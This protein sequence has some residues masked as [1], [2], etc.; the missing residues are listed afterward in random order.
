MKTTVRTWRPWP[1]ELAWLGELT[2]PR[3][4]PASQPARTSLLQKSAGEPTLAGPPARGRLRHAGA[5]RFEDVALPRAHLGYGTR[6]TPH[7]PRVYVRVLANLATC[8]GASQGGDGRGEIKGG[9][10]WAGGGVGWVG[11]VS[12]GGGCD[13]GRGA[14][15][16]EKYAPPPLC[17]D[18]SRC[19]CV[20]LSARWS[21]L[22]I[23]C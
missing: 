14:C 8:N 16:G 22:S 2:A 19:C 18:S 9:E 20:A 3:F 15:G 5:P 4:A 7:A 12:G 1:L 6:I 17:R 11:E 21:Q 10:S 13:P 23:R